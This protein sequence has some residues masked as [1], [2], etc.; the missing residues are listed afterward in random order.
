MTACDAIKNVKSGDTVY[1]GDGAGE[2][3]VLVEAFI[4]SR[5][6]LR[7]VT[8]IGGHTLSQGYY[9]QRSMQKHFNFFTIMTTSSTRDAI[10][11]GRA[12]YI[13]VRQNEVPRLFV[14]NGPWPL[15]VALITVSPPDKNGYYSL[16]VTVN[17]TLEA[18]LNAK[19]VIAEV[20][21]Q[22]PRTSGHCLLHM[23]QLDFIVYSDRP[24]LQIPPPEIDNKAIAIA[25]Y[26]C[27]LIP[28]GATLQ[29]GTGSVPEALI[30][31][32]SN[33]KRLGIHS[34]LLSDG[35]VDLMESGAIRTSQKPPN[36]ISTISRVEVGDLTIFAIPG[37]SFP[38]ITAGIG[39]KGRNLFINQINDSLGYF[40]PLGQFRAEPAEWAEG[41]HFIGHELESLGRRAG[42]VIR[43]EL[44]ILA[45]EK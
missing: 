33:K 45:S 25:N 39:K 44:K 16:G 22:M 43:E 8:I 11:E 7:D 17:Y 14:S 37:E 30:G 19:I 15:D 38:G 28:D 20:N 9:A 41:H 27:Q 21:K 40:I 35:I 32:L 23:N 31:L 29:F 13:S 6:R 2:P 1:L 10:K 34:G 12:D 42:E 3:E 18:A 24:L 26:I 36:A 5:N 4:A